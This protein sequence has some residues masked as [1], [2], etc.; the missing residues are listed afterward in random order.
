M[1]KVII[2]SLICVLAGLMLFACQRERGVQAGNETGTDTY[3]P[4]AATQGETAQ[5][6]K[7]ANQDIRGELIRVDMA[8]KTATVRLPNGM[9][10]TFKVDD[11]TMVM[12]LDAQPKTGETQAKSGVGNA[13][14]FRNLAGKEGSEVVVAWLDD[15]GA[16]MAAHINVIE[17]NTTKNTRKGAKK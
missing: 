7:A 5:S 12:G 2:C 13:A 9:E 11:R 16:K 6:A 14:A 10:Q 17:V 15:N 8:G 4:R 1:K 3:Q